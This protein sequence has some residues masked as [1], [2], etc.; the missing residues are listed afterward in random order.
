MEVY[1]LVSVQH[2][3][4]RRAPSIA[5]PVRCNCLFS[6]WPLLK[7]PPVSDPFASP[8]AQASWVRFRHHRGRQRRSPSNLP[9][10]E[11]DESCSAA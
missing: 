4:Q 3:V 7:D 6:G 11:R 9:G 10:Q 5:S 1:L 2:A 8:Y